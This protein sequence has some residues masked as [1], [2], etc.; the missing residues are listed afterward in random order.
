MNGRSK[1]GLKKL[2]RRLDP[3][4]R[5]EFLRDGRK[6]ERSAHI[7][8][9]DDG[10]FKVNLYLSEEKDGKY[11]SAY[12]DKEFDNYEEADGFVEKFFVDNPSKSNY[13]DLENNIY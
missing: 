1:S 10:K 13:N 6:E 12:A 8:K 7:Q 11:D 4:L 2:I 3:Q 5:D 9:T